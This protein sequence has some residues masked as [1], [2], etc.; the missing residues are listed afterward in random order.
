MRTGQGLWL[1]RAAMTSAWGKRT[2]HPYTIPLRAPLTTPR[3][4][5]FA[6]LGRSQR[7]GRVCFHLF[8]GR[9]ETHSMINF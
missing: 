2:L 8:G 6:G 3:R 5:W 9:K 4:S 7:R 1:N